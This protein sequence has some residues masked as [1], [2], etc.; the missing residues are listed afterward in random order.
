MV[1]II[2]P[3]VQELDNIDI[4]VSGLGVLDWTMEKVLEFITRELQTDM[5]SR[6]QN[7][8]TEVLIKELNRKEICDIIYN[9]I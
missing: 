6:L 7:R 5:Q 4:D 1:S 2:D 9:V 8:L 3:Y